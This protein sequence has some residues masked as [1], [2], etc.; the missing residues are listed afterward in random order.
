[1]NAF[2]VGILLPMK[3][4]GDGLVDDVQVEP[5]TPVLDVPDVAPDAPFHLAEFSGLSPE[6][7][8]LAPSCDARFDEVTYHVRVDEMR[9]FF[10]MFQ[11]VWARAY[12]AHVA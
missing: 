6:T 12:H 5:E 8:H 7:G 3:D 10:R 2:S 9:V 1:M 4:V 11:H